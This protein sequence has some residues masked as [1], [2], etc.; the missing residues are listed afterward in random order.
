[1]L[2]NYR[3]FEDLSTKESRKIFE[4]EF[5]PAY[6]KGILPAMYYTGKYL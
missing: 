6:N 2:N 1:M 4:K 5:I 3:N